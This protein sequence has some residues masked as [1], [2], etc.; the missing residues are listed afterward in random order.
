[1]SQAGN[2]HQPLNQS[3]KARG[4]TDLRDFG[5]AFPYVAGPVG[6]T[7]MVARL[8]TFQE[9]VCLAQKTAGMR[10][11]GSPDFLTKQA[12]VLS[13]ELAQFPGVLLSQPPQLGSL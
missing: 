6:W 3:S 1:M 2:K 10:A 4:I 13:H 7:W 9:V 11:T 12:S 8:Q 5:N